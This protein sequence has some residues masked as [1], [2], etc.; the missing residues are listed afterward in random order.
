M[1]NRLTRA[2][3]LMALM[4]AGATQAASD[5]ATITITGTVLSNTCTIDSSSAVQNITLGAIS[6]RDIKGKGTTGGK[7]DVVI[8]LTNC[9][10]G[11]SGVVVRASGTPDADDALAFANARVQESGGATGVGV[12][13]FQTDGTTKFV[14]AGTITQTSS[15]IPSVDN[16]LTYK[17]SFVGTKDAVT[18]G[19]FSTVV[20]MTFD[21]Q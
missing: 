14:P 2:T 11:T 16:T 5:T 17:A 12:Y 3:A 6:D 10:A 18:A 13:F 7:K 20:N 15:L 21:Y 4:A 9:G 8:K 19:D 1:M